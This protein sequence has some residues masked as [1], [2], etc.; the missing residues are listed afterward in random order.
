MSNKSEF[1]LT[2]RGSLICTK[3][4]VLVMQEK[5]SKN[6]SDRQRTTGRQKKHQ[7]FGTDGPK[8][9][10]LLKLVRTLPSVNQDVDQGLIE[11]SI[12]DQMVSLGSRDGAVVRAL[13]S[14]ECV[15]GPILAQCH[16]W[17]EFVVGSLLC[18]EMFFSSTPVYPSPQ[19]T[20]FPNSN[21]SLE[22]V[23]K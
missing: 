6:F 8:D 15:P 1:S 7:L 11:I 5:N 17:V 23:C 22:S 21:S 12:V 4:Y 13:A 18:S 3:K 20:T 16:R 2:Y 14:H 10:K 9:S 19:N